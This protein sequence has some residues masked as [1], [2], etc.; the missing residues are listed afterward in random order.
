[1]E[2]MGE[3]RQM[4]VSSVYV[5][6]PSY[7]MAHQYSTFKKVDAKEGSSSSEAKFGVA[8]VYDNNVYNYGKELQ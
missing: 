4:P 7:P 1:M 8:D 3:S 5:E 2:D 6:Q